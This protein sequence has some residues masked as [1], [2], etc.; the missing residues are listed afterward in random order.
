MRRS[1]IGPRKGD[2]HLQRRCGGCRRKGALA[3]IGGGLPR[4]LRRPP[5]LDDGRGGGRE[6]RIL[7]R[8][9][10]PEPCGCHDWAGA[11]AQEHDG[12]DDGHGDDL[13]SDGPGI[14]HSPARTVERDLR[15]PG[16]GGH[17]SDNHGVSDRAVRHGVADVRQPGD[18]QQ[19]RRDRLA[20]LDDAPRIPRGVRA[21]LVD[22][23]ATGI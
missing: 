4:A 3:D 17:R 20:V 19:P 7:R 21:L 11:E 23:P 16:D 8:E 18:G 12:H 5:L 14:E 1:R 15:V 2:G 6:A 13:R 10:V 9:A 22:L